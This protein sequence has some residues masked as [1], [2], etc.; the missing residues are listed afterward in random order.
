MR[1]FFDVDYTF[2]SSDEKLR[3]GTRDTWERLIEDGHEIHVWSGQGRRYGALNQ[4]GLTDLVSGVYEKPIF[5]YVRR[6]SSMGV[7]GIPDFVIDDYPEIVSIFGGFLVRE[8]YLGTD[9]DDEMEHIYEAITE[10]AETGTASH[11]RWRPR[12]FNFDAM[13]ERK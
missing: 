4:H 6:L 8:F 13:L 1:I 3:S 7:E 10:W 12:H 2:L 11:R 9:D 5:D